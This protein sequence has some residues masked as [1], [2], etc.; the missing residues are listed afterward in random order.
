MQAEAS[1]KYVR[2]P[3]SLPVSASTMTGTRGM[4]MLIW[5][6]LRAISGG[7][8]SPTSGSPSRDADTCSGLTSWD[9][10]SRKVT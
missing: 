5:L 6:V 10:V 3:M 7:V 2:M 9:A 8:N 1:C 4:L